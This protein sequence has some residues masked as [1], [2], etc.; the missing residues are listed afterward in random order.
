MDESRE[1]GFINSQPCIAE[2]MTTIPLLN[3]TIQSPS[4]TSDGMRGY[5]QPYAP[6]PP[7]MAQMDDPRIIGGG[8]PGGRDHTGAISNV[9]IPDFPWMREK[10]N[11]RKSS[12]S[13]SSAGQ[14]PD[15]GK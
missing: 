12:S 2:F 3:E 1:S 6:A 4:I 5:M 9:K 7:S 10:K 8:D 14:G 11:I 13:S 15:I